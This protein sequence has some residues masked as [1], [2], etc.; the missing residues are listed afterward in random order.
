[1]QKICQHLSCTYIMFFDLLLCSR[2]TAEP[3]D[4]YHDLQPRDYYDSHPREYN[5]PRDFQSREESR[6]LPRQKSRESKD[7]RKY[8]DVKVNHRFVSNHLV[9]FMNCITTHSEQSIL[10]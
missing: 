7:S 10:R 6:K 2:S 4:E 9:L 3:R 1:M 5:D 8:D